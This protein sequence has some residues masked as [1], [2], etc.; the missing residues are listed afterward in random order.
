MP[1]FRQGDIEHILSWSLPSLPEDFE[2]VISK[3]KSGGAKLG[4]FK[5]PSPFWAEIF[6]FHGDLGRRSCEK[7]FMPYANNK[8]ADQ[9]AHPCSLISVFVICCLDTIYSF[10]IQNF[11]S[12]A[13]L[14]SW[15]GWFELT[16]SE[17]QK[18]DFLMTWLI[19]IFH[20]RGDLCG[21]LEILEIPLHSCL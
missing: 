11:N 7:L 8:D 12:L 21:K 14:C 2:T 6:H 17:I 1:T 5:I 10:C 20:F 9:P 19:E 4:L 18:T 16:W 3:C 13:S 15:A